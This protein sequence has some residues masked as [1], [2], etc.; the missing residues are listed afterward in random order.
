M[1]P[2]QFIG[3]VPRYAEH[4]C[5]LRPLDSL[6][7]LHT[8]HYQNEVVPRDEIKVPEQKLTAGEMQMAESLIKVMIDKFK[9]ADYKDEYREA[10]E[11]IIRAKVQ[12]KEIKVM[13]MPKYEEIPDLMA[14]LKKSIEMA[15]KETA[16]AAKR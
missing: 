8:M 6:L 1:P 11:K 15:G 14:A 3:K 13:E 4:L 16:K 2:H 12:G 7:A 10:L 9:P 5:C